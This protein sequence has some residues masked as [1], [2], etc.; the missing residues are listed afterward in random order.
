MDDQTSERRRRQM[1]RERR[2]PE[3]ELPVSVAF[4]AVLA[5]TDDFAVFVSGLRV[6]S[7]GLDFSVEVRARQSTGRDGRD[8]SEALHDDR[9]GALLLGVEFSDGRRCSNYGMHLS[10]TEDGQPTLWP[11]G[12]SSGGRSADT[13]LF[14]SPL[15]PPGALRLVCAW[16]SQDIADSSVL[17]PTDQIL[18]GA[19]RVTELWP[20]EPEVH[21]PRVRSVPEVPEDSWFFSEV[22]RD[23]SEFD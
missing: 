11:G 20:W 7:N 21:E 17:L 3:N 9:A 13:S 22:R 5:S 1:L 18:E 4:D 19:S 6:F 2:A 16:P 15:P 10:P 8:L 12:G 14:L 23:E